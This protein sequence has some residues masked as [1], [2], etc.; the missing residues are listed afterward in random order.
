[1]RFQSAGYTTL[2]YDNRCWGDSEGTPRNQVDPLLQT[3]DYLDAFNYACSL[4][5]VDPTKIVYWGTS[6]SG[7]NAINAAAVNKSIKA[8]ITQV[9]FVS[10]EL[11]SAGGDSSML[12]GERASSSM[13]GSEPVRIPIFPSSR[14]E[15]QSGTSKA[16]LQDASGFDF[17]AELD[18]RGDKWEKTVT[19]QSVTYAAMH[20]PGAY[21][22]R[23]SPASLLMVV[24]AKDIIVN[25]AKQLSVYQSALEPKRLHILQDAGHFDPYF[26]PRFEENIKVQLEFLS[27]IFG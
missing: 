16:I 3:R 18:R 11:A 4:P 15:L 27:S 13:G 26:G 19:V 1:M 17:T 5:D 14:E 12:M 2:I 6:M 10:G 22:H 21:I 24:A 23:V 8:V 9:S 25:T 20:E 7:G